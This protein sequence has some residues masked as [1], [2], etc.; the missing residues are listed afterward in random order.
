MTIGAYL[1]LGA[2]AFLGML[3]IV[4]GLVE[5]RRIRLRKAR[6]ASGSLQK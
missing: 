6:S 1:A 4:V 2:P 3:G 5:L